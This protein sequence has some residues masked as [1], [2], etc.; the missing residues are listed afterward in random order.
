MDCHYL[1]SSHL[2]L[3]FDIILQFFQLAYISD[4][5]NQDVFYSML[6]QQQLEYRRVTCVIISTKILQILEEEV[7]KN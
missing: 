1:D 4:Q 3:D 2:P 7:K 5:Q 6:D